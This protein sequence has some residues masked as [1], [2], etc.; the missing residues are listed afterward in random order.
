MADSQAVRETAQERRGRCRGESREAVTRPSMRF[1]PI[2]SP[3]QQSVLMLHR[4]RDLLM[5]EPHDSAEWL[6]RISKMGNSTLGRL[7]AGGAASAVRRVGTDPTRTGAWVRS[8]LERKSARLTTV[9]VASSERGGAT[10]SGAT[11]TARVA[12]VLR[13]RAEDYRPSALA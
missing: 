4:S 8:L 1:V 9:A 2:K 7:L 12:W 5:R 13:A 10:G 6:G 11:R 3:E